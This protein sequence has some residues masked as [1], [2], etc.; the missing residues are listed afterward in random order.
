M[1]GGGFG[2]NPSQPAASAATPDSHTLRMWSLHPEGQAVTRGRLAAVD[3]SFNYLSARPARPARGL[4]PREPRSG[5]VTTLES[6]RQNEPCVCSTDVAGEP[7]SPSPGSPPHPGGAG[8]ARSSKLGEQA[9]GQ[10]SPCHLVPN[11]PLFRKNTA[12]FV[13]E[14]SEGANLQRRRRHQLRPGTGAYQR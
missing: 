6:L 7:C 11:F 9:V 10:W 14:L 2:Q 4:R 3:L 8:L 13:H 12:T 5:P 1:L